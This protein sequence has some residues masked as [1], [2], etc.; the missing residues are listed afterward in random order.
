MRHWATQVRAVLAKSHLT[1][2]TDKAAFAGLAVS[3]MLNISFAIFLRLKGGSRQAASK[4][5]QVRFSVKR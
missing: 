2:S 4:Q 5:T 3:P 1:H